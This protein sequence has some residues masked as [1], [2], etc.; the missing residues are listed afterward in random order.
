[1]RKPIL[2]LASACLVAAGTLVSCAAPDTAPADSTATQ[3]QVAVPA[4]LSDRVVTADAQVI[5]DPAEAQATL[6]LFTDYQCPYC[7]IMDDLIQ[8]AKEDYGDQ[9]R[10]VVRN[11][12]LPKHQ[13]AKAAARAAEAAAE[14]GAFEEMASYIFEH[15][16]EWGTQS[17]DVEETFVQ[18]AQEL[19]LDTEQF[20]SDYSSQQI[21]DRVDQDLQDAV[22]LGIPG[23]PTLILDGNLLTV[24]PA[25]YSTLQAPLDEA[26]GK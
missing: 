11:Y 22:D 17:T 4:E 13:N 14:Q 1:M 2:T 21:I 3:T 9:V 10:I 25:D 7:A 6:V 5:S 20:R 19:G 16:E 18:Y 23:T 12:P 24:N 8:Q 26:L 15:Q